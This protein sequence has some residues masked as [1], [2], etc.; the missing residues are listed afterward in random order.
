MVGTGSSALRALAIGRPVVVRGERGF[1]EICEAGTLPIFLRQAS[2]AS[3]TILS[4]PNAWRFNSR[5][6]CALHTEG[7]HWVASDDRWSPSGSA[8]SAQSAGS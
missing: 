1:S 6:C 3:A 4:V 8:S 2:T 5:P 7:K